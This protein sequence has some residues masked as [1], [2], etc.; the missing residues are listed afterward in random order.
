MNALADEFVRDDC[1]G[2]I[3]AAMHKAMEEIC[4]LGI[5]KLQKNT[6]QGYNFRGIESAMNEMSPIMVRNG[7]VPQARYSELTITERVKG[8]PADGKAMRFVVLKG[9]FTF[10]ASDGSRITSEAYGEAMDSGDKA[11]VKAQSVAFRTALFQQFVVPTA[12]MDPES[13]EYDGP[14]DV[15]AEWTSK[16]EACTTTDE[17]GKVSKDGAKVFKDAKDRDGYSAFAA[18]VQARGA[19]LKGGGDA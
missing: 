12:A 7:I 16:V 5:G 17:L 2:L 18:A 6:Q 11:V 13:D 1:H 15:L 9:T 14:V 19:V 4:R 3:H 8:D 10:T